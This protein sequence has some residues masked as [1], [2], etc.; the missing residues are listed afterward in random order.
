[1]AKSPADGHTLLLSLS[2]TMLI[3]QF[4]YTKLPYNPQKD[5]ALITQI[6][7]GAGD[8]GGAPLGAGVQQH[9]RAAGLSTVPQGQGRT[10]PGARAR[11]PT[12]RART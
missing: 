3:N 10:A 8:A 9:E 4:L 6:A 12:W 11:M 2:T 1:V 7:A 5:L